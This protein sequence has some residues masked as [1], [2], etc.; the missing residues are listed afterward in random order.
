MSS[1]QQNRHYG[2]FRDL[3]SSGKHEVNNI[4]NEFESIA[5]SSDIPAAGQKKVLVILE[6]ISS[7]E[8]MKQSAYAVGEH[9]VYAIMYID[10]LTLEEIFHLKHF[11]FIKMYVAASKWVINPLR[12]YILVMGFLTT[13][14]LLRK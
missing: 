6:K 13:T 12:A 7:A 10:K 1:T 8:K 11:Q 3:Y 2:A 5:R 4:L 14:M 9:M